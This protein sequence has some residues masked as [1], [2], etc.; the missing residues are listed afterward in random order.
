MSAVPR[1][2]RADK[3]AMALSNFISVV[4]FKISE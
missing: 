3:A 1:D 4:A 2:T